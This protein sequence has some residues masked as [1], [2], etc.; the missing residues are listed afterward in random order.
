MTCNYDDL[1]PEIGLAASTAL[2]RFCCTSEAHDLSSLQSHDVA[3]HPG[4]IARDTCY[5]H[6][7]E[8]PFCSSHPGR[9]PYLSHG[10]K[11]PG[12]LYFCKQWP[13]IGQ[14]Q[15]KR[16]V[17]KQGSL[18]NHGLE[19]GKQ[20]RLLDR[21]DGISATSAMARLSAGAQF[22]RWTSQQRRTGQYHHREKRRVRTIQLHAPHCH[23]H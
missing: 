19:Q 13:T 12:Q 7:P 4:A 9:R 22:A 11:E 21:P 17:W 20:C 18:L 10:G 16:S 6:Q 8:I 15:R 5:T 14:N 2:W 1:F 23:Q 3:G